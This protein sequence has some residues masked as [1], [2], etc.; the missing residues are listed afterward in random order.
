VVYYH[1]RNNIT[2][3]DVGFTVRQRSHGV[4]RQ[5]VRLQVVFC[6]VLFELMVKKLPNIFFFDDY[7]F[8]LVI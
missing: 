4:N 1:Q 5:I 2:V 3:C 8:I 7:W 6:D